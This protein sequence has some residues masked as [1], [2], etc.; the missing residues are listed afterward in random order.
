[1]R[2][3]HGPGPRVQGEL[4]APTHSSDDEIAAHDVITD[5]VRLPGQQV[6]PP[7]EPGTHRR[8]VRFAPGSVDEVRPLDEA[9]VGTEQLGE[10]VL[11]RP[12]SIE[13]ARNRS[14][15]STF[16]RPGAVPWLSLRYPVTGRPW[17]AG[18]RPH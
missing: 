6:S 17:C 18:L 12:A 1:M 8:R 13:R 14:T 7:L 11:R 16:A 5:L 9:N 15:T 3:T 2:I 10:L 4:C